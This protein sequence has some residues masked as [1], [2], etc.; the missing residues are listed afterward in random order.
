ME[1]MIVKVKKLKNDILIPTYATDGSACFDLCANSLETDIEVKPHETVMIG[2]GLCFEIPKG[3]VGLVFSRSGI[4]SKRGLGIV[5][6]VGVIDSDYRGEVNVGLLNHGTKT[7]TVLKGERVAQMMILPLPKVN[8]IE[9]EE[10]S[11]TERGT[12]GFG[13]TG[14]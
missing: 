4:S 1:E 3:Y 5:N 6:K 8:L 10:L 2:T 11:E 7:Q 13:S 9:V 14:R 12:G